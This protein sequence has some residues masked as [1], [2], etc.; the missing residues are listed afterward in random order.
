[1]P[2]DVQILL[3][4][5]VQAPTPQNGQTHSNSLLS[6]LKMDIPTG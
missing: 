5:S 4:L 3:L 1:M 6:I 2:T